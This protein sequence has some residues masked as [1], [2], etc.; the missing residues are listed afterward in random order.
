MK[1]KIVVCAVYVLVLLLGG[2]VFGAYATSRARTIQHEKELKETNSKAKIEE[3]FHDPANEYM[4]PLQPTEEDDITLRIRTE[5]YNVTKAQIQYTSDDGVSWQ[6]VDMS[7]EKHDDTGYYDYW[8]GTIPAQKDLFYYRFICGNE[9]GDYY[10]DRQLFPDSAEINTYEECWCVLPGYYSPEWQ[11]GALWYYLSPDAFYNGDISGDVSTSDFNDVNSW[12]NLR[13]TLSDKYGGDLKGI[14]EKVDYIK[15]LNPDAVFMNPFNKAYQNCGYG[16]I[17]YNQVEPTL[18]NAQSLRTMIE[19]LHDKGIKMGSDAVL[20]FTPYHSVYFD[21]GS[22]YPLDGALENEDSPYKDMFVFYNWPDNFHLSWS[23]PA[24]DHNSEA[25]QELLYTAPDSFLQYYTA[26]GMDSWRFDCGGWLYGRTEEGYLNE[27]DVISKVRENLE[28][29]NPDISLL[30]ECSGRDALLQTDAWTGHHNLSLAESGLRPYAEGVSGEGMLDNV[31][32]YS[33]DA[34]P[35]AL[36]LSIF[37]YSTNHD[38][39]RLDKDIVSPYNEKAMNLVLMTYIGSPAIYYGEEIDLDRDAEAGIGNENDINFYAMEWDESNWDFERY[40]LFR[41]L[42]ELRSE[43]SAVKTGALRKLVLDEQANIYAFGRWDE[44]GTVITVA[45][46]NDKTVKVDVNARLLSTKDDTVFTDWFTGKQYKVDKDGMLHLDVVPGGSIFVTGNESSQYR[47]QYTITDLGNTGA[48]IYHKDTDTYELEGEGKLGKSDKFTLA[49]TGMYGAGAI[50]AAAEGD[51]KA[52]LTIRQDTSSDAAAYN[53]LIDG[54][55]L[56]VM[57]RTKS[58]AKLKT[59][60]ETSVDEGSAVRIRRDAKNTFTV[61]VAKL[62]KEGK[63]SGEWETIKKSAIAVSMEYQAVAGFAPIEGSVTLSDVTVESYK[64]EILFDDFEGEQPAAM[65]TYNNDKN[66]ELADG[67]LVLDGKGELTWATTPGK[68]NDWTFK[69]KLDGSVSKE[70]DYAGVLCMSDENQWVSAGRTVID[71]KSVIYIGKTVDGTLQVDSYVEDK[72]PDESVVVQLQRIG[73]MYTAVYSYDE[74]SYFTIEEQVFANFSAENVGAFAGGDTKA[75]FDYVSFGDSVHDGKSINIPHSQGMI[76]I[77]YSDSV[78]AEK[79]ESAT[80]LSGTWEYGDEG[81]YQ[82]EETG[83][84]QLAFAKKSFEDFK[85]NV[86]L[87]LEGGDGYAAIGFGKATSSTEEKNGFL[88][89]YTGDNKLVL[90]KNGVNMAS[91][92]VKNKNDA[93]SLRVI[94]EVKNSNISVYAGQ[95]ATRVIS[96]KDTGYD[97]GNVCFYTVDR[98]ARFLN[99]RLTSLSATWNTLTSRHNYRYTKEGGANTFICSGE[100]SNSY[101]AI[102][103]LGVGVTDFVTSMDIRLNSGSEAGVLLCASEGASKAANGISVALLKEGKLVLQADGVIQGEYSLGEDVQNVTIMVVKKD[104]SCRVYVKDIADPVIKYEDSVERGGVYQLYTTNGEARFSG[105]GLEDIHDK[106]Y[107]NSELYQLWQKGELY[108][109]EADTYRA[110]FNN[111][112]DWDSLVKYNTDHGTWSIE[113]GALS[114]VKAPNWASGVTIYDRI[115]KEFSMNFKY[116]FDDSAGAFAGVLLYNKGIANTNNGAKYSVLLYSSGE[117]GLLEGKTQ[118]FVGKGYIKNFEI[119]KW[120]NLK[121]V[122][123]GNSIKVYNGNEVLIDYTGDDVAGSSGFLSFT[124]NKVL[125]SFDDVL[126]QPIK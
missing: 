85:L 100:G 112:D 77:D 59:V 93:K 56:T 109:P 53:V 11:L 125:V 75:S 62:D 101:G 94:L 33:L 25:L 63:A 52:V 65:L 44:D 39:Y 55:T 6:T 68:D 38:K 1:K 17:Y 29:I 13:R 120:Y 119:G 90:M 107:Y 45:S 49:S 122:C 54:T 67:K 82:T 74:E 117:V 111:V 102:T 123:S 23:G 7:F 84:T 16:P 114:C 79:Q 30:S 72:H 116:R 31:L 89:K 51:G 19:A 110:N 97:E 96:V 35:R 115:F 118:K 2:T 124:A 8:V 81:Y 108:V 71:G 126:I 26:F 43:Y 46:Q 12:N 37:N 70:G 14:E 66:V 3:V 83:T 42:G 91:A 106:D 28:K 20:T 24:L 27:I 86:T 22:N 113:D 103:L 80:I 95:N 32:D 99:H 61:A 48:E 15:A 4:E 78:E 41:S 69:V 60:C 121:L 105:F 50:Y 76:D 34:F 64:D 104:R 18:G 47:A 88:L 5:R 87:Q 57:A 21:S 9:T 36:A 10:I 98:A 92:T 73:S 58:G 40:N